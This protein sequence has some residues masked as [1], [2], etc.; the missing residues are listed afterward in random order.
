MRAIYITR[1]AIRDFFRSIPRRLGL[2]QRKRLPKW[3]RLRVFK[4]DGFRC[5]YCGY[6]S[7]HAQAGYYAPDIELHA[8]HLYPWIRGGSDDVSNL[9]TACR[10]CNLRKGSKTL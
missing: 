5:V 2:V 10:P 4:R 6:R 7:K 8:D 3:K 1:I 9:V